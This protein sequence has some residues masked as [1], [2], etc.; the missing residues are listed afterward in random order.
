MA[1]GGSGLPSARWF[2]FCGCGF[3]SVNCRSPFRRKP[4]WG[5]KLVFRAVPDHGLRD[6]NWRTCIVSTA[7]NHARTAGRASRVYGFLVAIARD[8]NGVAAARQQICAP[9]HHPHANGI[10]FGF[11]DIRTISKRGHDIDAVL[12]GDPGGDGARRA[13]LRW[14]R[15]RG[16]CLHDHRH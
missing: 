2:Q 7:N 10:R 11:L 12:R 3:P 9:G 4:S 8:P 16:D 14:A 1:A 6:C 13:R 5:A 15:G